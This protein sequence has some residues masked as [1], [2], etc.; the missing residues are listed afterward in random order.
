M[1]QRDGLGEHAVAGVGRGVPSALTDI[2]GAILIRICEKQ[3]TGARIGKAAQSGGAGVGEG[4]NHRVWRARAAEDHVVEV[5][6]VVGAAVLADAKD[7]AHAQAHIGGLCCVAQ[8][9]GFE[10]AVRAEVCLVDEAFGQNHTIGSLDG[11]VGAIGQNM[12]GRITATVAQI[13]RQ[14][15]GFAALRQQGIVLHEA[16]FA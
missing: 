3:H 11:D 14:R 16:D 13:N 9:E 15:E 7:G 5:A 1:R 2:Q 8:G 4:A 10:A 12:S 6:V